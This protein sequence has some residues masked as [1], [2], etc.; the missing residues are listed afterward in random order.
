MPAATVTI[1]LRL[2]I[3]LALTMLAFAAAQIPLAVRMCFHHPDER[4]YTDAA[5][6]MNASGDYWTPRFYDGRPR[7]HKPPLTYWAVA[8]CFKI[9]GVSPLSA[10]LPALAAA[11]VLLALTGALGMV[12][13]RRHDA[14]L[15]AACMLASQHTFVLCA[16][17]VTPDIF[18]TAG[19]TA[20]FLGLYAQMEAGDRPCRPALPLLLAGAACAVMAKGLLGLVFLIYAGIALHRTCP[21]Q[22]RRQWPALALLPAAFAGCLLVV[23][24]LHGARFVGGFVRDQMIDRFFDDRWWHK[25]P[26][27]AGYLLF[28]PALFAPWW[29]F[30]LLH[31]PWR[32]RLVQ[33]LG[34]PPSRHGGATLAWT[35]VCVAIFGLSNKLTF[36]YVL[37][38]APL[39]AVHLAAVLAPPLAAGP[40]PARRSLR[41]PLAALAAAAALAIA[42]VPLTG[43]FAGTQLLPALS[44]VLVAVLALALFRLAPAGVATPA[45]WSVMALAVLPLTALLMH[46]P[47]GNGIERQLPQAIDALQAAPATRGPVICT[48]HPAALARARLVAGRFLPVLP[49]RDVDPA[50]IPANVK[51]RL[52]SEL[53]RTTPPHPDFVPVAALRLPVASSREVKKA[54]R[55]HGL[56]PRRWLPSLLRDGFPLVEYRLEVRRSAVPD[57]PFAGD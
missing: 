9:F 37:G 29:P 39:L 55:K 30:L 11:L 51:A 8:A 57:C 47:F 22:W 12:V 16:N 44:L 23:L 33:A 31:R 7:P 48:I 21:R 3:C 41:G 18:L 26:N 49:A 32:D 24:H 56:P 43:G 50:A 45:G 6:L 14:A 5:L 4:Y 17:R 38:V 42:S 20:G 36:R 34:P 54:W 40:P 2:T 53:D 27:I 1:R 46:V 15:L 25:P 35:L 13:A 19:L 28:V 10:R 52:I